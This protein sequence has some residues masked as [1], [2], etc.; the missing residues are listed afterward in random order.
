[1]LRKKRTANIAFMKILILRQRV[2]RAER[3]IVAAYETVENQTTIGTIGCNKMDMRFDNGVA[4]K[5][6]RVIEFTGNHVEVQPYGKEYNV[7][8]CTPLYTNH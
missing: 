2:K 3:I 6:W 1:M 8:S 5:K 7:A 4:G